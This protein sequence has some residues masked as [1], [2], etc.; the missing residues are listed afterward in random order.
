VV[1]VVGLCLCT[2]TGTAPASSQASGIVEFG[3]QVCAGS[4]PDG[5]VSEFTL[6]ASDGYKITVSGQ[7]NGTGFNVALAIRGHNATTFYFARGHVTRT[8]IRASFGSLG[9]MDLHFRESDGVRRVKVPKRCL[10]RLPAVVTA[11]QGTFVGTIRFVGEN[12]YTHVA[13][14]RI[15]GGVGDPLAIDQR[16]ECERGP[17]GSARRHAHGVHLEA[18]GAVQFQAWAGLGWAFKPTTGPAVTEPGS[19][20]FTVA[21]I[22]RRKGLLIYRTV[23][24]P[25]PA[26][27]FLFEDTLDSATVTPPAPFTGR[28]DFQRAADGSTTW[29]GD[30]S[31]QLPGLGPVSLVAPTFRSQLANDPVFR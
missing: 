11:R 31:V 24:A 3:G 4:D 16:L 8:R 27:D 30:L 25:A 15:R 19:A 6:P 2:Y 12:D 23:V 14:Q 20:T 1:I 28:A 29:S 21:A 7:D 22:E 9:L 10:Q 18:E 13:A 26:T 17:R 5:C